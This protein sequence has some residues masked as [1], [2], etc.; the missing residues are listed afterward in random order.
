MYKHLATAAF[1]LAVSAPSQVFAVDLI[2]SVSGSSSNCVLQLQPGSNVNIDPTTG[3]VLAAVAQGSTCPEISGNATLTVSKNGTGTGTVTSTP[4]GISCGGTC[5]ADF[6]S[7]TSVTLNP[8]AG[9]GSAFAGW[10]GACTGMGACIVSMTQSQSVTATFNLATTFTLT[11][12][13]TGSGSGTVTSNPS[14]I[15]CGVTCASNFVQGASVT[16]TAGAASGS[17]FT[18]WSGEGCSGTGTCQVTMSQA[19]SVSANFD[20]Q[21]GGQCAGLTPTGFTRTTSNVF[22]NVPGHFNGNFSPLRYSS[23]FRYPASTE[24]DWP[25][26]SQTRDIRIPFSQYLALEFAP[27]ADGLGRWDMANYEHLLNPIL[28]VM[29]SVSPCPGDF[30]T[31]PGSLLPHPVQCVKTG[32]E[33]Q[34]QFDVLTSTAGYTGSRCPIQEGTT[35][36]LNIMIPECPSGSSTCNARMKSNRP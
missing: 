34:I 17:T 19:R 3:N 12:N 5:S 4:S 14:G 16:L 30:G 31:Q 1:L 22:V 8:S 36:Y 21:G 15:N 33:T 29:Y 27:D 13:K 18:G 20:V 11:V 26:N 9:S 25:G 23:I 10:A 35:Y 28:P 32:T 7:G 2:L 24:V 6:P